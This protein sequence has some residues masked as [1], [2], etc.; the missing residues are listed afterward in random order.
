MIVNN[1]GEPI[2]KLYLIGH[3]EIGGMSDEQIKRVCDADWYIAS[4][5]Q[6][7]EETPTNYL[8]ADASQLDPIGFLDSEPFGDY[9][10]YADGTVSEE[11]GGILVEVFK[12]RDILKRWSI[13]DNFYRA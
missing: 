1:T 2:P 8:M 11:L 4:L 10:I 6:G 13:E 7:E 3:L 12:V 5:N 9:Y